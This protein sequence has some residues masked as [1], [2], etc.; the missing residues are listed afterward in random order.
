[1]LYLPWH[2]RATP[3]T[4]ACKQQWKWIVLILIY[5]LVFIYVFTVEF[6]LNLALFYFNSFVLWCIV[7]CIVI[8]NHMTWSENAVE[9]NRW[10]YE[11]MNGWNY[12]GVSCFSKLADVLRMPLTGLR[13]W[14]PTAAAVA[15]A[16]EAALLVAIM[17]QR[18][19]KVNRKLTYTHSH[20]R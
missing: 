19:S 7:L 18:N 9:H 5:I 17:L 12:P 15:V 11:R 13:W 10:L 14:W 16:D 4:S 3:D 8:E 6:I 20:E 1:M 2:R